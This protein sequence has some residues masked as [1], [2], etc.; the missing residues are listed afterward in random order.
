MH[1]YVIPNMHLRNSGP[2]PRALE[3]DDYEPIVE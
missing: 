3:E 1:E 2:P